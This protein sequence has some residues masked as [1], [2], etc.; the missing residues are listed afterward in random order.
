VARD[1]GY[2]GTSRLLARLD[3]ALTTMEGLERHRGHFFNWYDTETLQPLRPHYISTVDSGNLAGQLLALRAGL[4]ALADQPVLARGWRDGVH[5]TFG[6]LMESLGQSAPSGVA[7]G[8]GDA[9]ANGGTLASEDGLSNAVARFANVLQRHHDRPPL[10]QPDWR[11]MADEFADGATAILLALDGDGAAIPTAPSDDTVHPVESDSVYWARLLTEHCRD[12]VDELNALCSTTRDD[13]G[14]V[15]LPTLRSLAVPPA[16]RAGGIGGT[17]ETAGT[18]NAATRATAQARLYAIDDLAERAGALADMEQSFLYDDSRHLMTIGYN[19]DERRV[20]SGYYDLLAS[21]ARLG[22]FVAIAQ[23]HIPQESWFALGRLLTSAAGEPVLLS[24]SGSMF[25]YLMPMLLMP[26]YENTLLDQSCQGAV[27]RQI[28]YGAERGVPWGISESGYNATDTALNYQYRA[29]GVPGLGLK[30]GLAEDLVIAPYASMMA[31]MVAPEE[32]C[33]NLQRLTALGAAGR[34]GLYEAI[35]YTASRL[36]RG[37]SSAVVRSFMAH[38]QG[39]GLLALAHLLQERPMQRHFEADAQLQAT[40]LLLQERVPRVTVFQPDIDS[41][42]GRR[43]AVEASKAAI[44]VIAD[45][46]TPTPEVQLLSNGRYHVMVTQAGGGYSRWK[47]LAVT[48]W[49]E[50]TTCD[51]WGNFCYLRD[52]ANGNFWSTAHQ[53]TAN[54]GENYEAI[55]SEGRAE[56]RR[57]DSGIDTHTEI[58]VSPEDDI[59]L[60][61][62]RITNNS[63]MRR[64]IEITSYT[65]VVLAQPAADALHPAFSKLFVQTEILEHPAAV[66]CTRRPRSPDEATPWLFQLMAVHGVR[67]PG[68]SEAKVVGAISHETDRARFIGRGRDLRSPQALV[69]AGA[70]SNSAGS[71]LDPVAASRCVITL[72]PDQAVVIDMVYGMAESRG[73]CLALAEKYQ[74]RRLADRVFELAWTHA[75]VVLRQLNVSETE[76]QLY[77]RL[78]GAVIYTQPGLRADPSVLVRNRRGQ[79]GLWGYAIS[80]DLPI[81]LLQIGSAD[82]IELVR[83]LVQAH[84]WW[85]LKGLAVDLVIWNEERDIYRQRLQEQILGLITA[86]VEAHVIDRPGGIFVR[87]VEQI[88]HEDRILLQSI[89]RAVFTDS[90]GSLAEQV[91]RRP[92]RERRAAPF[93]PARL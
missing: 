14:L 45:P 56:F 42:A 53:P 88:A 26:S 19:V 21:E 90:R 15:G 71:V 34:Y 52:L 60:R 93:A 46:D 47:D 66:L 18:A 41:R 58:V 89:A 70:L 91:N 32:A 30:R 6:V 38:H 55:F 11:A 87:H 27:Q 84:A 79:S 23:G 82:N 25:E 5:D 86:G 74:D 64:T 7:L 33:E 36:P 40:L 59:E 68:A 63:R 3:A 78:A 44:R 24:W 65:E 37:Q 48:R 16:A 76:A 8:G 9:L 81:V 50:D 61:R 17:V 4:L 73:A 22:V 28:E 49:S 1:F 13:I 43:S 12:G 57:R 85:R 62:L 10:S 35:D 2:L 69:T 92:L 39:M 54:T 51:A 77:G 20:D 31:L 75:Q 29:F 72:V 80:G 67:G 83:Q